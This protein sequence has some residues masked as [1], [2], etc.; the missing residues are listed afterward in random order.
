MVGDTKSHFH[1]HQSDETL[2]LVLGL[3]AGSLDISLN[4]LHLS[5]N[6]INLKEVITA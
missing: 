5:N 2:L 4:T 1:E 3:N 6:H